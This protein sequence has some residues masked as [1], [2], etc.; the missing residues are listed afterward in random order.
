VPGARVTVVNTE[1]SFLSETKT[2]AEGGYY[3]PYLSPGAYR[4]TLEAPGFKR[5]VHDG[6][7]VRSGE[8]PRVDIVLEVGSVADSVEVKATSPLL[9]TD[10]T[11]VAQIMDSEAVAKLQSP[12]GHIVRL[13]S[14]FANVE[15]GGGWHISGQRSRAVGYTLDGM[16]AKTPATN[17]FGDTD[18]IL[19]P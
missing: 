19:L 13:L 9:A 11:V 5:N 7:I 17:S 3:V 2:S 15:Y 8:T 16:T 6:V 14:A 1:T 10:S 4:I 18:A 12:Q